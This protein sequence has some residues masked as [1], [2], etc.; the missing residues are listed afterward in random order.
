ML[1]AFV[2]DLIVYFKSYRIDIDPES[3]TAMDMQKL[4]QNDF[5]DENLLKLRK[6]SQD[7]DEDNHTKIAMRDEH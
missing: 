6:M 7:V 3:H 4:P 2:M 5:V 1:L